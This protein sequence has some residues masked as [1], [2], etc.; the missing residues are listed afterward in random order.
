MSDP[1]KPGP[2]KDRDRD[3]SVD[4]DREQLSLFQPHGHGHSNGLDVTI[5]KSL[6]REAWHDELEEAKH[7]PWNSTVQG[8]GLIRLFSR[9]VMGA[10]FYALGNRIARESLKTYDQFTPPTKFYDLPKQI[11][12]GIDRLV[13]RP[14]EHMVN[15]LGHDGKAFVTFRPTKVQ[16]GQHGISLGQEAV[17]LTFDFATM[18]IGDAVGRDIARALDPNRKKNWIDPSGHLNYTQIAKNMGYSAW[19]YLTYNQGED[20]AVAL[21]YTFFVRWQRNLID[22]I[23]PGFGY[24]NDRR[25]NG[26]S[27]KVDD[28]GN[29]K[30]TYGLEGAIDLQTRFTVY[31]IGTVMYREAYTMAGNALRNWYRS[32]FKLPD[33]PASLESAASAVTGAIGS[34]VRWAVRDAIKA[35]L[36]M[37]PAVPAFWLFRTPQAK[38]KGMFIHPEKGVIAYRN[39]PGAY[40]VQLVHAHEYKRSANRFLGAQGKTP[41]DGYNSTFFSRYD[42]EHWHAGPSVANPIT[43]YM[44]VKEADGGY[45]QKYPSYSKTY[46]MFDTLTNPLGKVNNKMRKFGHYPIGKLKQHT[47]ID[48]DNPVLHGKHF[49]DDVIN[50]SFAYTPYFFM[51]SDVMAV[52]W[53]NAKMDMAIERTIDG[54][55]KLK[56][57]EVKEGLG[58]IWNAIWHK[59]FKDPARELEAQRNIC[60]DTSPP[61]GQS[62]Q[63]NQR[64]FDE[65]V[66]DISLHSK[67]HHQEGTKHFVERLQDSKSRSRNL[68]DDFKKH[69]ST[70][71]ADN[72]A[73]NHPEAEGFV[74]R[75]R[76]RQAQSRDDFPDLGTIVH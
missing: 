25:L 60:D 4:Q 69:E 70:K 19:K 73:K 58:E 17:S 61:D 45:L 42:G 18:S 72:I 59:P 62:F 75:E 21:P 65:A 13:T 66:Q 64:C 11:A 68:L 15:A 3:K 7:K 6:G 63:A 8:R 56:M 57:G 35:T 5:T 51:K 44:T 33:P 24:D 29:V 76:W 43:P 23:S 54:A 22:K 40:D 71:F 36:Y 2:N 20:W 74:D 41:F 47:G 46:G 30:G 49:A 38:Y 50:A 34:T 14:L 53:D 52:A 28:H 55:A 27:F 9:G 16:N 37:T 32:G 31:N 10:T 48:L 39:G 1:L 12:Y 26:G 67:Y